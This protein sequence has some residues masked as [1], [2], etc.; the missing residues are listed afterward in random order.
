M[1]VSCNS[2]SVIS[3]IIG[4]VSHRFMEIWVLEEEEM[5][6]VVVEIVRMQ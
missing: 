6:K 1:E 5:V 4:N 2:T 3:T